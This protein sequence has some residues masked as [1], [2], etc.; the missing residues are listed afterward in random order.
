MPPV[1]QSGG[2]SILQSAAIDDI[3]MGAS[4][5]R[6]LVAL[7]T[8]AD[9]EGWCWPKQK[10]IADRLGVKRQAVSKSLLHLA[11]YG[12]IEIHEQH[13]EATG[14]QI[15]S[16]YRILL[17]YVLPP[18]FR[19]T[20]Q[21]DIAGGV[22]VT[23]R[24]PQ[25]SVADP[26]TSEVAPPA[27]NHVAPPA[28]S[29]VAPIEE[30]PIGTT[31]RNDPID[32]PAMSDERVVFDYYREKV[33]PAAKLCPTEKIRTRLKT[34]SVAELKRGV[35]NFAADAW[36]MENNGARGA[37]WFFHSDVRSEQFLNLTPR[38]STPRKPTSNGT[39]PSRRVISEEARRAAAEWESL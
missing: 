18:E 28:T 7:G 34:F 26:A 8:Y 17:D 30:R 35:D 39:S 16:R 1:R 36:W 32:I 29:E 13:D 14:S 12:Y 38:A 25:P 31:H 15:Q 37:A 23:L 27:T 4:D 10:A 22:K 2:L 24:P 5:L 11:E 9:A 6:I 3:R 19:R 21:P 33:Q 20:P